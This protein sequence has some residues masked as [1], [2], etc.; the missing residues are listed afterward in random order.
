VRIRV[1]A[2]RDRQTER[3]QAIGVTTNADLGSDC[4]RKFIH[5]T[6]PAEQLLEQAVERYHL[7]ARA[8]FRLLKVSQTIADL[9]AKECIDIPEL[10]EALQYREQKQV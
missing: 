10:A 3:Y 2:A 9:G 6:D 7:S 4:V 5:L 1:Q 8:Y